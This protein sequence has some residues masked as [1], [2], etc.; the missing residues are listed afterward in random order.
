MKING[1]TALDCQKQ[2]D[3]LTLTLSGTDFDSVSKLDTA[4][5]EVRTDDGDLVEAHGGYALRT[6]TFDAEKQ[7][8]TVTCTTAADDTTQQAIGQLVTQLEALTAQVDYIGM[9][10]EV[11]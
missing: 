5:L 7:V 3:T 9:M 11:E 8:Y 4:L 6:I 2:G 10:T 1:I